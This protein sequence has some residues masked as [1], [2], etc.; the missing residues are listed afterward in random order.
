MSEARIIHTDDGQT[1][2]L[3]ENNRLVISTS[4]GGTIYRVHWREKSRA[5]GKHDENLAVGMD[6]TA[7]ALIADEL[8]REIEADDL[9]RA[10]YLQG[11]AKAIEMLGIRLE[12]P[13]SADNESSAPLE[14]MSTFRHPLLLQSV[15]RFQAD[16]VAELLPTDG[17]VKIR[18]DTPTPPTGTP[19]MDNAP[20]ELGDF[21]SADYADALEKDFNH[22][23]TKTAS[24]YYP[25]T[26]RMA[27]WVGLMGGGFKKVYHCPLRKRP[28]SESIDI[29]D[30]IVDHSAT[31]LRNAARV[32]HRIKMRH[33]KVRRMI[34]A[35]VWRNVELGQPLPRQDPVEQAQSR[36]TGIADSLR[37]TLPADHMHT[38]YECATEW[39]VEG[40]D[41]RP[42]KITVDK[43]AK[44]VL[45]IYRNWTSADKLKLARQ[46]IVKYSYLDAL[47]FYPLGLVHV[48]GNTIRALTATFREFIDAGMFAS[49]PGFLYSDDVGKQTTNLFRVAPG[50]GM[51]I[52]TGGKPIG[53]VVAPLPY[54]Q[55]GAAFMQFIQHLEES[56]KALGGEASVP[57]NE[58]TSNMPVGTMLAQIEQTLKPIKGVFKGLHRSQAEEFQLLKQRFRE[59]PGALTRYSDKP[60][61]Q[62]EEEELL[63]ALDDADLVPM[64]DPST[65]SHV[66]R[67]AIAYAMVE[68][69]E[70]APYLFHERDTA[71]RFL[72]MIRV[73]DPEGILASVEEVAAAKQAMGAPKGKQANP[74]LDQA[75]ADQ[76]EADAGLKKAET[77]AT[78]VGIAIQGKESAANM[79]QQAGEQ[80]FK[81][82]EILADSQE[83]DADRAAHVQTAQAN[84]AATRIKTGAELAKEAVKGHVAEKDAQHDRS[85]ELGMKA[86][87]VGHE[88]AMADK[89]AS[90]AATEGEAQRGHEQG[91]AGFQAMNK[92]QGDDDE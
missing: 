19:G 83:R 18:D 86:V 50:S 69:A 53:E 30:L 90:T 10:D 21:N 37:S 66:E 49:F 31:D 43:D 59:D 39:D 61:R 7:L 62:W 70:K 91:I 45:S 15:I 87:D 74:V 48:L 36:A 82:T 81:A 46:E 25:D 38:I 54:Q 5:P 29:N 13:R 92:A 67:V 76:A 78:M 17:P 14:G 56:G 11:L 9:T 12:D 71:L 2:L 6:P 22:Y 28:V 3:D 23:L 77:Q 79:A 64:A 80:Q 24:E 34:K 75:K 26:T 68:L 16:F 41:Y 8:I 73:P 20:P 40:E 44:E 57:L 88:H 60:A 58:G 65:A 55:P 63:T 72:R 35:N 27:F 4:D 1:G 84:L 47:G 85:H 89:Q 33:S 52:K 42:Y 51:P 32:T